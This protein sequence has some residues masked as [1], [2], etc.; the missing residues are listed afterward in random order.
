MEFICNIITKSSSSICKLFFLFVLSV[1]VAV[2]VVTAA[3]AAAA[4]VTAVNCNNLELKLH[5]KKFIEELSVI[6]KIT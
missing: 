2:I 6:L 5:I 1:V 4:A 3:A